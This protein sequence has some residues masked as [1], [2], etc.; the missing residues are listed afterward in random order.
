MTMTDQFE[1]GIAPFFWVDHE[2][3]A[4]ACLNVGEY[5]KPDS[6]KSLS[7]VSRTL[8]LA[9]LAALK[10]GRSSASLTCDSDVF[11]SVGMGTNSSV[12]KAIERN[13]SNAA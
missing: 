7:P 5:F 9:A 1:R 13:L 3:S 11:S 12:S 4:S 8:A 10:M 2:E 6:R